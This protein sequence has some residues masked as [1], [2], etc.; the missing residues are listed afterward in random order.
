MR[1]I[2]ARQPVGGRLRFVF[3]DAVVSY[4]VAGALTFGE[5]ARTMGELSRE[6]YR[7]PIAIDVTFETRGRDAT[8]EHGNPS[9]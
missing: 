8:V 3:H 2:H 4:D 6:R 9:S 7:D 5:I 1:P